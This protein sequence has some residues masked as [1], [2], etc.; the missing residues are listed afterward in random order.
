MAPKL[1]A[2]KKI[3]IKSRYKNMKIIGFNLEKTS[4][5]LPLDNGGACLIIDGKVEMLINEERLNRHQYS[6][7]FKQSINYLLENNGLKSEDI[8]LF[9]A[10]RCLDTIPSILEVQKQLSENGFDIPKNKIIVCDHHLSHAYSAYYPSGFNEAIIMVID[11]DGNVLTKK[12]K[13]STG[14]TKKYFKNKIEHNSYF[15]GKGNDIKFLERDDIKAE[16]NGFGGVYRYFTYFCGFYGYKFAG[17]LMGLSAYG[18]TRNKYKD[19]KIFN[20]LPNGQIKCL[21]PDIDRS[22]EKSSLVVEKWLKKRGI[23]VKARKPDEEIIEDIEDIAYLIQRELDRALIYKVNYLIKK[24]GMKN[25]CI[26]GG[27]GLNA[28]S[29]RAII[30]NT[31]IKNIFIQPAA[32]DSGQ[33]LGNA[34][35][36]VAKYDKKHISRKTVSVYQGKEYSE[37]DILN[38]LQYIDEP[39]KYR[40]MKFDDLAEL[41]AKKIA[42]NNIIG[43]FQGR[44]E[45]GP[46][47]LGNRSIVAN[48]INKKMKDILNA[49]VK[50]REEFRPFAPSILEEKT[51]DWF[52]IDFKAPYMI[53]NAQVKNSKKVPSITHKDGSARLQTVNKKDNYRY[54]KLISEFEKITSVPIVINTSLNDNESIVESPRDAINLFLRTGIDYLFV[55]DYFIEKDQSL[56]S[57]EK[58]LKTI[59]NKWSKVASKT[60]KIQNA[61]NKVLDQKVLRIVKRYLPSGSKIFDYNCEWGEYAN[62]LSKNGYHVFAYNNSEE[63]INEARNKFKKSIF[64]TTKELYRDLHKLENKFDLVLSNLWL[65]IIKQREHSQFL[66]NLKKLAKD[67]GLILVSFCHPCFDYMKESIITHRVLPKGEISYNKEIKHKKI[68]HENGL[69]FIDYHR[70]LE[71][72]TSLFRKNG[73]KIVNVFESDILGTNFYP[74]FIIFLLKKEKNNYEKKQ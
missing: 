45:M 67:D 47:A 29:N 20:L 72:Y 66:K 35:Y 65:C 74:D 42:S 22:R 24:T 5:N 17:K 10:S 14:N 40:K 71:Y 70:P 30:D 21:I 28:V 34:F 4:Y 19:V 31:E 55:G 26:A 60:N 7:G 46:R 9:V 44:S 36:G 2:F 54:H 41:A 27:V 50:H 64:L 6:A 37:G 49:K 1:P 59:E 39:I 52:D 62:L 8:D 51:K 11:G 38:A 61:K 43:W 68:V 3:F 53:I 12:L 63:M 23:K 33:C 16:E 15:I 57:R 73:L 18:Q 69:D 13:T 48:P 25:L 58:S 32:G 56:V